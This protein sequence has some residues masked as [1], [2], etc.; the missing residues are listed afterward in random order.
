MKKR[1]RSKV[2]MFAA[3]LAVACSGGG[4]SDVAGGGIG[5]SGISSGPITGFGSIFVAGTK[6]ETDSAERITIDGET[7]SETDLKLGMRTTVR[8]TKSA[9]GSTGTATSI[10]VDN[11]VEGPISAAPPPV[12]SPGGAD[13]VE[14]VTFVVLGQTFVADGGTAFADGASLE[15][16]ATGAGDWV[17]VSGLPGVDGTIRAT[18]VELETPPAAGQPQLV[19]VEGLVSGLDPV[20]GDFALGSAS[21]PAALVVLNRG[22]GDPDCTGMTDYSDGPIA[23]GMAVEVEGELLPDGRVCAD[24]VEREDDFENEDDFEIEGVVTA[25]TDANNFVLSGIPV[26]TNAGTEFEPRGLVVVVGMEVEVEGNLVNGVL[27]ATEV[28]Q[29]ESLEIEAEVTALVDGGPDFVVLGLT[30]QVDR[31]GGTEVEGNYGVGSAVEVEAVDNGAGGF[32][33]LEVEVEDD[34]IDRARIEGRVDSIGSN[35]SGIGTFSIQGVT[36][37]VGAGTDCEDANESLISCESF[38][39]SLVV[40]DKVK[41]TDR[42]FPFDF[43]DGDAS[44]VSFED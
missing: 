32:T 24:E 8:G 44:D 10:E 11:S 21:G 4:G 3:S 29:E 7:V 34:P 39:S 30:I 1:I 35:A 43:S 38:F 17:E 20:S 25:V 16:L 33:A 36:V 37:S 26:V 5:G 41:A 42:T 15:Q 19:E 40:G 27:T 6:W 31:N 14:S 22:S 18:R 23:D 9:D 28:E 2:L 13:P 12:A